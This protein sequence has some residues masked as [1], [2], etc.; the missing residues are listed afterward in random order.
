[1]LNCPDKA[2]SD[3]RVALVMAAKSAL[4]GLCYLLCIPFLEAM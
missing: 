4:E 3:A 1:V 2:L